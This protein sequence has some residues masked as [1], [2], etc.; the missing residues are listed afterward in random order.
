MRIL[1][2]T[3]YYRPDLSAG[4]FRATSLVE[5]LRRKLGLGDQIDVITT[6]PNRYQSFTVDAPRREESPGLS[7]ERLALS[8]HR[9]GMIDQS[10]AFLA[11]ARH[12]LRVVRRR[13]Y[14]LVF[15]TS[16]RLMTAVLGT[17]IARRK[18]ARLYLD[19][20]DIFADTIKDVLPGI[21]GRLAERFFSIL[22]GYAIRSASRVNV[23]SGGFLGYFERRYPRQ[24]FSF[25]SNGIDDEFLAAAPRLPSG[26]KDAG[27]PV[28][29]LYAGNIGEG[30]GLDIVIPALAAAAPALRFTIIGDGGRLPAL[31]RAVAAAGATNVEVRPPVSRAQLI[32]AYRDADV[33]FLHLND[34]PAFE[35]VL[36]SKI[37][38]YAALG[39]PIWAGVAGYAARFLESEVSNVAVFPPCDAAAAVRVFARLSLGDAPRTGFLSRFGRAAISARLADDIL[40]G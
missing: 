31:G 5:A 11:F 33:L 18:G 38:E 12:A 17:W 25:F 6:V 26:V 20:R 19:I 36:P 10:L 24:R 4:S 37:F 15:A 14:D 34:H 40:H 27:A 3:F 29:V 30:Q 13:D 32:E 16:S 2:L 8:R 1:V 9:S 21:R 23:V 22:E 39:K 7:I 28:R 35:K